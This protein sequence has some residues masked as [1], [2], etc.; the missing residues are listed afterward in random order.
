MTRIM[1]EISDPGSPRALRWL[2][3]M[4]NVL[5]TLPWHLPQVVPRLEICMREPGWL[6]GRHVVFGSVVEGMDV[7]KK[8]EGFGTESGRPQA[9][10]VIVDCG[11]L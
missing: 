10:V 9:K 8:I 4:A 3:L 7:V 11:E 6:D 1:L 5:D 2:K